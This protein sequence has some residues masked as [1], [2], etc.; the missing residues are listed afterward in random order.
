MLGRHFLPHDH[1]ARQNIEAVRQQ[2]TTVEEEG[3]EMER[4]ASSQ[5]ARF[6]ASSPLAN[7]TE[8]QLQSWKAAQEA[9]LPPLSGMRSSQRLP[10]SR[11]ALTSPPTSAQ[12]SVSFVDQEP[13][14]FTPP[15]SA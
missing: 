8:E 15:F 13:E 3:V 12:G 7:L 14:L 10:P 6:G 2:Q 9:Q 1:S 4:A 5:S 11:E